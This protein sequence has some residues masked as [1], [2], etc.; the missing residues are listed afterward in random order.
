M[1]RSER[2][3]GEAGEKK[4]G[5]KGNKGTE[6]KAKSPLPPSHIYL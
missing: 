6:W 2:R 3:K 5:K 1:G 4:K